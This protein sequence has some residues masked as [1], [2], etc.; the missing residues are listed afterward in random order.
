[1][2]RR[3][4]VIALLLCMVAPFLGTFTWLSYEKKQVRKELKKQLIAGIDK[5]ELVLLKFTPKQNSKLNWEHE[6]EFEFNGQMY[7]V[8]AK[9]TI[10]GVIHY[11]CWWDH[12]ETQLNKKLQNLL[13]NA[14]GG[15]MEREQRKGKTIRFYSSLF[16]SQNTALLF[17]SNGEEIEKHYTYTRE[18][19]FHTLSPPIPPPK[20]V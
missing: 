8:V 16:F 13:A 7:D 12:E 14:L 19:Y 2:K 3:L 9:D 1:M 6:K 15:D 17:Q 11:W 10:D 5:S 18:A 4:L 20:A